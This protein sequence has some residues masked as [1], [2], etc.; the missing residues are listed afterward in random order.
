M[1]KKTERAFTELPV[2]NKKK[3]DM[4]FKMISYKR[5]ER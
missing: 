4:I 1:T 5:E 3:K 2:I